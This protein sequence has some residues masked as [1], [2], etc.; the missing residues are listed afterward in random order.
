[1]KIYSSFLKKAE[2]PLTCVQI[3]AQQPDDFLKNST[4]EKSGKSI[5]SRNQ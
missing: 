4:V 1:M 5:V 3:P 2:E